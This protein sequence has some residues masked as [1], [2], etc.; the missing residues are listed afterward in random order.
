MYFNGRHDDIT[1]HI[2]VFTFIGFH[3]HRVRI[4]KAGPALEQRYPRFCRQFFS[5]LRIADILYLIFMRC[6][7]GLIRSRRALNS[8]ALKALMACE[9]YGHFPYGF[10]W[11]TSFRQAIAAHDALGIYHDHL[12]PGPSQSKCRRITAATGANSQ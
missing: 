5:V 4:N 3:H 11:H 1:C 7:T 10:G 2:A 12:S 8:I 9:V 6:N